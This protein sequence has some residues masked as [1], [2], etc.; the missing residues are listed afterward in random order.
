MKSKDVESSYEKQGYRIVSRK[1]GIIARLDRP[2]WKEFLREK[3]PNWFGKGGGFS[4]ISELQA[5]DYYRRIYSKDTLEI[6]RKALTLKIPN[7]GDKL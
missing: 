5:A 3:Y 6:G 4:S 7:S 1:Y 2:D